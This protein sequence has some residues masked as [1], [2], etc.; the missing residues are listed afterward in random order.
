MERLLTIIA[1]SVGLAVM[2]AFPAGYY[3]LGRAVLD[4]KL[5]S[6]AEING[7]IVTEYVQSNPRLWRFQQERLLQPLHLRPEDR[8]Q[9]IRQVYDADGAL[10]AESRDE[11]R[12]PLVA[13]EAPIYDAGLVTGSI[14]VVRSLRPLLGQT[15]VAGL[16]GAV[17]ALAVFLTLRQLPLRALRQAIGKLESEQRHSLALAQ[18]KAHAEA[19]NSAKSQFLATMSHEIR[20]PMNG[21]IG[22]ADLLLRTDL[23]PQ[24]RAHAEQLDQSAKALLRIINDILDF[25]KI[26]AGHMEL[27]PT[28][29]DL[30]RL[31]EQT[32]ATVVPAADEKNLRLSFQVH[33]ELPGH[34]RADHGRLRQILIN[35]LGNAIKFTEEGSVELRCLPADGGA[36]EGSGLSIRFEVRD[37]GIGIDAGRLGRLFKPF[38]QGDGSM[39][40]RYGGTGLGLAVSRELS[41]LMGGTIG[42]DSTP[43]RGSMFWFTI[44]AATAVDAPE[45]DGAAEVGTDGHGGDRPDLAGLEVLL[46]EDHPVN[47]E[48]ARI[49]LESLGCR[50]TVAANGRAA[51]EAFSGGRFDVVLMDCQM[52]EMD[53]FEATYRIRAK[54][55]AGARTPILALTANAMAGDREQ[56]LAAGMDD[57]LSKPIQTDELGAALARWHGK[58]ASLDGDRPAEMVEAATQGLSPRGEN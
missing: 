12:P 5:E 34:V 41:K 53:G 58:R 32:V 52:P 42:V 17:L 27:D 8:S 33:P 16:V 15:A 4:A 55:Q 31:V 22:L 48:I 24:Q 57:Y 51:V 29:F 44:R 18:E 1:T 49:M 56:C 26:E 2:L 46:A 10:I 45:R 21:V 19:A 28:D 47:Q 25:S 13:R 30:R 40:R 38:S 54:E 35:L 37:T 39:S 20:T 23:T 9:E 6:E 36:H 3:L 43:G 14:R 7:R 11:L 50:V